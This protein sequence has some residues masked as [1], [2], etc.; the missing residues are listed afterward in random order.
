MIDDETASSITSRLSEL[1]LEG[2]R[3][4]NVSRSGHE[5]VMQRDESMA[6][7]ET[8]VFS[9]NNPIKPE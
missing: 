4:M 5:V 6:I 7:A 9:A 3:G 8:E 1:R 2:S